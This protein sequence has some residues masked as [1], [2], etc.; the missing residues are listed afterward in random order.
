MRKIGIL[1]LTAAAIFSVGTVSAN[2]FDDYRNGGLVGGIDFFGQTIGNGL[3]SVG[4]GLGTGAGGDGYG[5]YSNYGAGYGYNTHGTPIY[6][7]R[8][9]NYVGYPESQYMVVTGRSAATGGFGRYCS[10]PIKTCMLY[11]PSMMGNSCSCK[12]EASRSHGS[13]TP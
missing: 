5:S 4:N 8:Q 9:S 11:E 3:A 7:Y 2:A 1:A 12:V 13:V 10:T 6:N